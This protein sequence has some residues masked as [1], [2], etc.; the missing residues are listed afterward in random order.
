MHQKISDY[1]IHSENFDLD[2]IRE[3]AILAFDKPLNW[4]SFR[5]VKKVKY[6]TKANRV[7]HA[8]TLDPLASGLMLICTGKCTKMIEF[9]QNTEKVYTGV[10]EFGKTTPSFDLETDFN[11]EFPVSHITKLMVEA[12]V[13]K[14]TGEI[15]QTPP[16]YSAI[17]ING[18]RAYKLA[19]KGD[20][21][22]LKSR[23]VKIYEFEV[24]HQLPSMGFKVRCSKGTYIRSLAND[25]GISL[26]SGSYLN[27]LRRTQI[28]EFKI[29]HAFE[30]NKFQELCGF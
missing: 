5:L 15:Q 16:L 4:T 26:G 17:K 6:F 28:G 30:L 29:E 12:A 8:G 22:D 23:S 13:Q 19:R 2:K 27:Q 24:D 10:F 7:G 21:T 3:G 18:T 14:F 20:E 25:F 1:F 11:R 9:L